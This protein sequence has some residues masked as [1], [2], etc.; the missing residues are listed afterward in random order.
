MGVFTSIGTTFESSISSM[1]AS[2]AS[3]VI[4]LIT[5]VVL[6]AVTLYFTI[7]GYMIMA[8]R[9]SE[10]LG[11]VMIKGAKIALIAM[12]GLSTGNFMTYVVGAAHGLEG[13]FLGA[14]GSSAGNIY[15]LMDNS[16]E[17]GYVAVSSAFTEAGDL[18]FL[19]EA[20]KMI[21]LLLAGLVGLAGLVALCAI[22][23]GIV[24]LAKMALVVVL[25]FG[26]LFV[27]ALMFPTTVQW[28]S[29][30]LSSVL[31]YVFTSVIVGAFLLIFINIFVAQVDFLST[32]FAN[33]DAEGF[34]S[35][36]LL[37]CVQLFL[38]AIVSAYSMMQVPAVAAALAGGVSIGAQSITS[39]VKGAVTNTTS[40][41]GATVGTAAGAIGTAGRATLGTAN[42]FT[43]GGAGRM[44]DR[45]SSA[46]S[47]R[48]QNISSRYMK[49]ENS[50]NS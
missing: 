48:L 22:G 49:R 41:A 8:G 27:C 37:D 5:P 40:V 4:G 28:F 38:I 31:N 9:I 35:T 33:S 26:P 3:G 23:A 45:A 10:P 17:K 15:Q 21:V 42:V 7:T 30:W 25:G 50:I 18:N 43:R 12:V 29:H 32:D 6:T 1:T 13:D 16:W 20:A 47:T 2:T 14:M 44:V 39:M 46:T 19:T 11:D 36:V 34:A 24:M